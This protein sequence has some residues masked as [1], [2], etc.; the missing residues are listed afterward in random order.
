[1]NQFAPL[2]KL[3]VVTGNL[4]LWFLHHQVLYTLVSDCLTFSGSVY[5]QSCFVTGTLTVKT[6]V[7]RVGVTQLMTR[8][9]PL[10]VTMQTV[11]SQTVSALQTELSFLAEF[12]RQ[13]SLK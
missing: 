7:T 11:H 8:M 13:M 4:H 9:L 3:P 1:M 6:A 10:R 2:E 12:F 5:Q